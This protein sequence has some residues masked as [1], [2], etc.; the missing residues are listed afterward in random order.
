MSLVG[1][2]DISNLETAPA[3]RSG[4]QTKVLRYNNEVIRDGILREVGRGGQVFFVHNRVKDIHLVKQRL[5]S[6]IPEVS[7]RFGHGQM[8]ERDLEEVMTDFIGGKFDLFDRDNNRRKWFGY[9][10]RKYNFY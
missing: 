10:Q 9:S 7:F 3:E 1:V 5:E 4:V 6:L 2:R 8:N